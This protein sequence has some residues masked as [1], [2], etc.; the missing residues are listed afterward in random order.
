M[1]MA[2]FPNLTLIGPGPYSNANGSLAD[3]PAHNTFF[4]NT[5][6]FSLL[7]AGVP[8]GTTITAAGF[9]FGTGPTQ[10]NSPFSSIPEPGTLLLMGI[11]LL[12]LPMASRRLQKKARD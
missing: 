1:L 11:G 2:P 7:A 12:L 3:N 10:L 6:S 4:Q 5:V 9:Y 8:Q